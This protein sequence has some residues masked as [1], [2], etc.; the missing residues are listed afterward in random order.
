MFSN[1]SP[2]FIFLLIKSLLVSKLNVRESII[3]YGL[4]VS[5]GKSSLIS[6]IILITN[7]IY[8]YFIAIRTVTIPIIKVNNTLMRSEI[9][10]I[11]SKAT[12][13]IIDRTVPITTPTSTI[14]PFF[15]GFYGNPFSIS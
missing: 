11:R 15:K 6:P 2:F 13:P 10:T 14:I 12:N 5:E 9:G 3:Y 1:K 4:S 8:I 7:S